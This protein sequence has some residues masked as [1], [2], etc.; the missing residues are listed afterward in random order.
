MYAF[1]LR[2][3]GQYGFELPKNEIIPVGRETM[4]ALQVLLQEYK[5]MQVAEAL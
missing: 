2:D 4:A 1:E 3:Q 5:K